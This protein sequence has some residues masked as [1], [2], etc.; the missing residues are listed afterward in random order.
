VGARGW[1]RLG[2]ASSLIDIRFTLNS[3]LVGMKL[4][5]VDGL[6]VVRRFGRGTG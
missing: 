4:G 3:L 2:F 6:V 5:G 1:K